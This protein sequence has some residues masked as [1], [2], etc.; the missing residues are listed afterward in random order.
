MVFHGIE[1]YS[2]HEGLEYTSPHWLFDVVNYLIFEK[3]NFDGLYIF[4]CLIAVAT[5]LL[6]YWILRKKNVNWLV[7]FVRNFSS[8]VSFK[9][10]FYR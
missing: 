9:R 7:A 3:A 2:W 4:V 1:Q 8:S 5:M 10:T 6:F